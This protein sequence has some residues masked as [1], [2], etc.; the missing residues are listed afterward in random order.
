MEHHLIATAILS[1]FNIFRWFVPSQLVVKQSST[2]SKKYQVKVREHPFDDH[3]TTGCKVFKAL[4]IGEE[5][6]RCSKAFSEKKMKGCYECELTKNWLAAGGRAA[7]MLS[8]GGLCSVCCQAPIT[9]RSTYQSFLALLQ[10]QVQHVEHITQKE[11][12][13]SW[14][15]SRSIGISAFTHQLC[16]QRIGA[17]FCF[18]DNGR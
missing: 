13:Y 3:H 6:H 7:W 9:H 8:S 4:V 1:S 2:S 15:W 5:S 14:Q 17:F 18:P 10:K 16:R 11:S 12:L